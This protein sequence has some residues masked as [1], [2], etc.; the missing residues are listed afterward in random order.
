MNKFVA[1]AALGAAI[2]ATQPVAAQSGDG[3]LIVTTYQAVPDSYVA[4]LE[5]FD[6]I[7]RVRAEAGLEPIR[8][9]SHRNGAS[10]DFLRIAP[11]AVDGQSERMRAATERLGLPRPRPG[12]FRALVQSRE[13]TIVAGPTTAAAILAEIAENQ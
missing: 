3:E 6:R 11:Q 9:Y 10:W 7:D 13:D 2:F 1:M 8:H 4:L 5:W 12:Q